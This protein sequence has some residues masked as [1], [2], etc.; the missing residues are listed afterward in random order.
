MNEKSYT[1]LGLMSGT[2]FDGIDVAL[3]RTDGLN[4]I[5]FGPSATISYCEEFKAKLVDGLNDAKSINHRQDRPGNLAAL[6]HDI[7]LLHRDAV[8]QFLSDQKLRIT[9]I[10]LIG[11]HGQTILHR[12]EDALTVQLGDGELLSQE[13]GVSIVYDMR[14][15]DMANSGQGAPL[16]PVYHQALARNFA[17]DL[18]GSAICFL[19]IGGIS[20]LT[21]IA[22]DQPL[23]AFDC[24]PGNMLIDQWVASQSRHGFDQDGAISAKGKI[25]AEIAEPYLRQ[26]REILA[27]GRSM[28]KLDFAPLKAGICS[29]ED[30]ARTLCYV[31]AQLIAHSVR[32]LPTKVQAFILCGG[33]RLNTTLIDEVRAGLGTACNI[34]TAEDVDLNGDALEAQAWA[35][36]AVRCKKQLPISFPDTTGVSEP[37]SGGTILDINNT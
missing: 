27:T 37:L 34:L 15:N 17:P 30:G 13:L 6:E 12:P 14:A 16:A 10:D 23:R 31:T 35:Y 32:L 28:D 9:D 33:G 4:R 2:S 3:L 7:T 22:P 36:L 21:Y 20:N 25:I 18:P 26:G 1:V 11:F 29:L 8:H 5:E 19:N 24:G